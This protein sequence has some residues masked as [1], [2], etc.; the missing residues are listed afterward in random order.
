MIVPE[1]PKTRS[2]KIMRRLL[3]DVAENREVGDVDDAGRLLG[4]EPHLPGHDERFV[5]HLTSGR[6]KEGCRASPG[7]PRRPRA[8]RAPVGREW[9]VAAAVTPEG[10]AGRR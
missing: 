10:S 4:D 2:G 5:L 1:L 6:E 7:T 9:S 3:Q 8:V